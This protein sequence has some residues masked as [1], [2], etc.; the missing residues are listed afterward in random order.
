MGASALPP[1][2][3]ETWGSY[4]AFPG[5][6]STIW[7]TGVP[8]PGAVV[9]VKRGFIQSPQRREAGE[10][11]P[12]NSTCAPGHQDEAEP[13]PR[14]CLRFVSCANFF[15]F[16]YKLIHSLLN[17]KHISP[18]PFL[19]VPSLH[20]IVACTPRPLISEIKESFLQVSLSAPRDSQALEPNAASPA[21]W[22]RCCTRDKQFFNGFV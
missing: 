14:C 10:A 20:E 7:K 21:S 6:S 16:F 11:S 17:L 12:V 4:S 15:F 2:S 5:L 1:L 19:K 22:R 18:K 13:A 8:P 9:Q 3:S